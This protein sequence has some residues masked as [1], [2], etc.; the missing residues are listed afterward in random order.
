MAIEGATVP[1]SRANGKCH[2]CSDVKIVSFCVWC[3]HWFC[4]SCRG[5]YWER[6]K[7][8]IRE[9]IGLPRLDCCGPVGR[10]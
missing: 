4:S 6:G 5:K 3:E 10:L 9:M 8:A 2:I 1:G 7:A